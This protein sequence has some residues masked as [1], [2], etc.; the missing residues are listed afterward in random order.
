MIRLYDTN[1]TNG[2]HLTSNGLVILQPFKCVET[3]SEEEWKLDVEV[4]DGYE[5]VKNQVIVVKTK[6]A[7]YQPFRVGNVTLDKHTYSFEAYH[8]AYD[9]ENYRIQSLTITNQGGSAFMNSLLGASLP[10]NPFTPLSDIVATQSA[11]FEN[12]SVLEALLEARNLFGCHLVF[13]NYDVKLQASIGSNRG[14]VIQE[15]KNLQ[16]LS[17]TEN[18]DNVVT[19]IIPT[20]GDR[21]YSPINADVSYDVPYVKTVAFDSDEEDEAD[22]QSDVIAQATAYLNINKYP[23]VNYV[24]KSDIVQLVQIGDTVTVKS[25]YTIGTTVMAYTYDIVKERVLSV[26]FGNYRPT[27]KSVFSGYAKVEDIKKNQAT[28]NQIILD[29]TNIINGLYQSGY[30]VVND[31]EI[32]I[33]DTLPKENAVNVLRMNLGG[34]GFSSNGIA[35]PFGSA[36]TLDGKFNAD[37]IQAGTINAS[38]INGTAIDISANTSITSKVS[39]T[40]Y[41]GN[42]IAS[43]INQT[44]TTVSIDASKINLTGYVTL[45]NL[46]TSGQTTINGGNITTGTISGVGLTIGSYN[47]I[48]K[49]NTSGI[50]AGHDTFSSAPFSVDMAG[51]LKA[52]K[53]SIGGWTISTDRIYGGSSTTYVGISTG[54]SGYA[55]WAGN[56]TPSSAPFSV[57]NAGAVKMNSGAVGPLTINTWGLGT[58]NLAIDSTTS[59]RIRIKDG[60]FWGYAGEIRLSY[61]HLT[62]ASTSYTLG[63]SSYRWGGLWTTG[64]YYTFSDQRLKENVQPITNGVDLILNIKPVEY[65]LVD[66]Q[67]KHFGF[68]AQEVKEVMGKT[69]GDFGAYV[70][71][72]VK[73]DWDTSDPIENDKPHYLS[74]RYEEFI[75]PMVQTIQ[76]LE[77]RIS[78]LEEQNG[79]A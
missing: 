27:I 67:R 38:L 45:A 9:L 71:P 74:L 37:Y 49:A 2:L 48:F 22:I 6:E 70:D 72:T 5:I 10:T 66:G 15:G 33:V 46:S 43:R 42:E 30:V 24:V 59:P 56:A 35:G 64:G 19:T 61:A 12:V 63:T 26:E 79:T 69:V 47:N 17:K 8:I 3:K 7:L 60:E 51:N 34:I 54:V 11:V 32:Y 55:F 57:T 21:V 1:Y 4:D 36:W 58:T 29:Q 75:A 40:D 77:K 53:G 68:I 20:C 78:A 14:V 25:D 31:N 65:T 62:S 13:D 18:W 28:V 41:N 76:Y 16:G 23:R 52:T 39:T 73:P 44:A 50:S